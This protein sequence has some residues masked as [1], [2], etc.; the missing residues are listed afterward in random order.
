MYK[1]IWCL[2]MRKDW[3]R[4]THPL[5]EDLLIMI[6][7]HTQPLKEWG[8]YMC[9]WKVPQDTL[10]EKNPREDIQIKWAIFVSH[11]STSV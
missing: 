3:K 11:F 7:P 6:Q 4:S 8:S 10:S 1:E 2:L 9:W 5:T